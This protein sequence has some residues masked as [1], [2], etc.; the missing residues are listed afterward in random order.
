MTVHIDTYA[1]YPSDRR[2]RRW[3]GLLVAVVFILCALPLSAQEEWYVGKPIA[4]FTFVGLDTVSEN[5]LLPLV[6]PYIGA[7]FSL[8]VFWEIQ[9]TLYALDYFESIEATSFF[10]EIASAGHHRIQTS[11]PVQ[12]F[13]EM[14]GFI[15]ECCRSF[16]FLLANP[17]PKFFNAA[18][19][20]VAI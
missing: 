12:C 16:P 8:E 20:P 4:D 15:T 18:P 7:E 17:I 6:R 2:G 3:A 14:A 19:I 11:Q 9:E 10:I 5:E 1:D 13:S